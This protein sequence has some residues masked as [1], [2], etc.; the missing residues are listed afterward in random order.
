M[1]VVVRAVLFLGGL[2]ILT[3]VESEIAES[4]DDTKLTESIT[5]ESMS[6]FCPN[7][8]LTLIIINSKGK[9]QKMWRMSFSL[10]VFFVF[11]QSYPFYFKPMNA[12]KIFGLTFLSALLVLSAYS[13]L[14]NKDL[15]VK[16]S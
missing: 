4:I 13:P 1:T 15:K 7:E 8:T 5:V 14:D 10:T 2:M 6:W 3:T 9:W 11:L 16:K 12:K